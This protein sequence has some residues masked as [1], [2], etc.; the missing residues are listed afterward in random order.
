MKPIW[1]HSI[2]AGIMLTLLNGCQPQLE[3]SKH[4]A[5]N[6]AV[7]TQSLIQLDSQFDKTDATIMNLMGALNDQDFQALIATAREL[8]QLRKTV[9]E[10]LQASGG[11]PQF[12]INAEQVKKLYLKGGDSYTRARVIIEKYWGGLPQSTQLQLL[13]FDK[14]AIRLNNAMTQLL[15]APDGSD[16][17]KT[18]QDIIAVGAAAA[19]VLVIAGVL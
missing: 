9:H 12:L 13:V 2:I 4:Y 1:K 5:V 17:T 14:Q 8:K 10:T 19:K 16:I 6:T 18:I 11:L 7:V 15:K 3:K